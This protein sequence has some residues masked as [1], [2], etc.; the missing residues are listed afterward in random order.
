MALEQRAKTTE[1][2]TQ[3]R[4]R[5]EARRKAMAALIGMS[6]PV[7]RGRDDVPARIAEATQALQAGDLARAN[8]L[9]TGKRQPKEFDIDTL[10]CYGKLSLNPNVVRDTNPLPKGRG[11][12]RREAARKRG[13][14]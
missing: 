11:A 9:L 8:D 10:A 13:G 14:K 2:Q 5:I 1:Q 7:I 6:V 12:R 4:R 3:A